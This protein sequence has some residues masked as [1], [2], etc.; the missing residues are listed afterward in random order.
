M[1]IRLAQAQVR[2][3]VLAGDDL[4]QRAENRG[5][6]GGV[7]LQQLVQKRLGVAESGENQVTCANRIGMDRSILLSGPTYRIGSIEPV[8][9]ESRPVT[10]GDR[11]DV[12]Y[13]CTTPRKGAFQPS[14][15]E[16]IR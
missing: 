13:F 2:N 16:I 6:V 9:S 3:P 14:Y 12:G 8:V 5:L 1:P 10:G 15:R 4:R 7:D 11:Y